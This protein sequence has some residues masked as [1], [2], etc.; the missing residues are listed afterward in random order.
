MR[1]LRGSARKHKCF[2]VKLIVGSSLSNYQSLINVSG[3]AAASAFASA[4]AAS[5]AAFATTGTFA[6]AFALGGA[7]VAAFATV[8][9]GG[10]AASLLLHGCI[11]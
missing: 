2:F 5:A 6:A 11:Y 4:A 7:A 3:E 1:C 9:L 10:A 8:A